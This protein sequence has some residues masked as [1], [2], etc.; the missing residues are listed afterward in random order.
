ME[1]SSSMM[2]FSGDA[3]SVPR[4]TILLQLEKIVGSEVFRSSDRSTKLLRY[5]VEQTLGGKAESLKEYTIGTE[6]L[7]KNT[8]FDPRLDH[9]VRAEASRLRARL[10]KYYSNGGRADGVVIAL[11]KGT[12]VP[13]FQ[14]RPEAEQ[15][16]VEGQRGPSTT[17]IRRYAL[18]FG[19]ISAVLLVLISI[20]FWRLLAQPST[21]SIAVLPFANLS[22]DPGQ[23]FFSDGVSEEIMTA[24]AK[25]PSLRVIG[26]GSAFE[27]KD[28]RVSS[29]AAGQLLGV[30]YI[31]E[32]SVR[33]SGERV[34]ITAQLV[35]VDTGLSVWTDSYDDDLQDIFETQSQIAQAVADALQLALGIGGS[36][37]LVANRTDDL[38]S[39]EDYL[40]AR[41]F[42]RMRAIDDAL[43][44]LEPLVV[45]NP[46]F[47][48]AWSLL[49]QAY[50]VFP[51]Y[52]FADTNAE[53][54]SF[55]DR[56]NTAAQTAIRLDPTNA[57]ARSVLADLGYAQGNWTEGEDG[58]REA[59]AL[60]PN[61]PDILNRF[62]AR[63][64]ISGR[65][66]ESLSLNEKLRS[67]EP[68][69][70]VYDV[71]AA[72]VMV[73][74]GQ[75]KSAIEVLKK[76]LLEAPATYYRNLYLAR[77]Y[78]AVGEYQL[79]ADTLL[80]TPPLDAS[81]PGY[82]SGVAQRPHFE[83]A[84]RIIRSAPQTTASPEMLPAL[85]GGLSF[86]YAYVGALE[87]ILEPLAQTPDNGPSYDILWQA[88][89]A[90][91]RKTDQFK[92][93]VTDLGLV[94]LWRDRGWPDLCRPAGAADFVCD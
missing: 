56:A 85:P 72:R 30:R 84:A 43:G 16:L 77:A 88:E 64:L 46:D 92:K 80:A 36:S 65:I 26:R 40:R 50:F 87:R 8:S 24:L 86:V 19:A 3:P 53:A 69:V 54:R 21:V 18:G 25:V 51:L 42:Y 52:G 38:A 32:G 73:T 14:R 41:S 93:T 33:K 90:P 63:L 68:F 44:I 5:L 61:N 13:R 60:D 15:R 82:S 58:F 4:D 79:A 91:L 48:P 37:R 75:A 10:E 31:V 70:P 6:A 94:Q 23:E 20:G 34:R 17:R 78:A 1:K 27:I 66:Q 71:T 2:P 35:N 89:S 7:G 29:R 62:S 74:A 12:Y 59:L 49:A 55:R 67:L 83:N 39:Y 11:P 22:T 76:A 47:A 45:R 28:R 81:V 57:P 9:I